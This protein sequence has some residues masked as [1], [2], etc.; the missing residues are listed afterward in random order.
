MH[1]TRIGGIIRHT[2]YGYGFKISFKT[3]DEANKYK[4]MI[5]Y[6]LED[7]HYKLKLEDGYFDVLRKHA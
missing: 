1:S 4:D 6:I 5:C 7:D 2:D 3:I